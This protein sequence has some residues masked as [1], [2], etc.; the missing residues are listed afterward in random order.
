MKLATLVPAARD[1]RRRAKTKPG[2]PKNSSPLRTSRL[3]LLVVALLLVAG[4]APAQSTT[5]SAV[6]TAGVLAGFRVGPYLLDVSSTE[7]TVAFHLESPSPA[8]VTVYGAEEPRSF[9]SPSGVGHFVRVAGL[10]PGSVYRYEVSTPNGARTPEG[11]SSYQIRT[12]GVPGDSFSF[13]VYGDPRPGESETTRN[14]AAV[15]AQMR[16]H[17]PMFALVLGDMVDDG[18]VPSMWEEFFAVESAIARRTALYPT[19]GD[20][21]Y[22]GGSGLHAAYF[23]RLDPGYYRFEWAGVQ[24]F[25]LRAWDTRGSQPREDYDADSPQIRWLESQLSTEE[26]Q[27][28]P[29]RVVFLHDP[30]YISRG[31]SSDDL[32]R[33]LAPILRKHR[34]D[35]VFASWHLYERSHDRGVTYVISGGAG[36]EILWMERDPSF[37]SQAEARRH[38]FCRVDV[39]A[40]AMTIRGIAADGTVLD[41]ITLTPQ[42]RDAGDSDRIRSVV[43]RLG[44]SIAVNESAGAP[45]LPVY[46][47]SYDCSYCRRLLRHDLPSLARVKGV[48]LDVS[49]FDLSLEGT[50]DLFL[51]AGAEFG[52]QNSDIPA[53]FVG[54][55]V[56][57][58]E[59]E[60]SNGL[61]GE[62][63][64][65]V[66]DPTGYVSAAVEPF[67]EV[68]DTTAMG[69]QSFNALTFA[70]VLGAGLLDG[71][72]PCAFTTII[73]LLSYL[74]LVGASRQRML[75]T[76]G[77]FTIAVF[78]TYFLIGLTFF[79]FASLLL[80]NS[81]AS[82]VVNLVLL[83]F[84]LILA[85]LSA[86]DYVR[87]RRGKGSE[88]LLQLPDRLKQ[89]IRARIRSFARNTVAIT[90]TA[91]LLGIIV[92]GMELTCTGQVYV[93]IVTMI[94]EPRYR[95]SAV[96]YLVA[97]NLAFITPLVIVF[98]VATFGVTSKSIEAFFRKHVA[99]VK[100]G[101][102]LLFVVMAGIILY[103][104]RWVL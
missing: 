53:V 96:F 91:F 21:D 104:V 36:A 37:P 2:L 40:N 4:V 19:M 80:K 102:S 92:S 48:A 23:P 98:L 77:A 63:D 81:T 32:R 78:L 82:L 52:R 93:P 24:F 95:V 87:F 88:A 3:E 49:Y 42:P 20:N 84:V 86:V 55:R 54:R 99:T 46:L 47:F 59:D 61:P 90:G 12:A 44:R 16:M 11:D 35:V 68:H 33:A 6:P 97:Y 38:H 58:G 85:V 72:N 101:F 26:A 62:I 9:E 66:R 73:F 10:A 7:A 39:T 27:A 30:V 79:R 69:E 100:L 94:S 75:Y 71:V 43:A 64:A 8:A 51:N 25:A 34:V 14:H 41:N 56:L 13:A 65:F 74:S 67:G 83:V 15:V 50:Y 29:F 28:A 70:V 22:A 45:A 57:G 1:R 31:R 17:D 76:G 18:S 5:T 103:N 60:I 89:G